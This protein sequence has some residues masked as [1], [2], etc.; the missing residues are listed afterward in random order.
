MQHG[1]AFMQ[2]VKSKHGHYINTTSGCKMVKNIRT[3][4]TQYIHNLDTHETKLKKALLEPW[5]AAH[6]GFDS[7]DDAD[8]FTKFSQTSETVYQGVTGN[9]IDAEDFWTAGLLGVAGRFLT[10]P[11]ID[12]PQEKLLTVPYAKLSQHGALNIEAQARIRTVLGSCVVRKF[13]EWHASSNGDLSR[14]IIVFF[15]ITIVKFC[16]KT[17]TDILFHISLNVSN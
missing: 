9:N 13:E 10:S 15:A 16:C 14:K 4:K 1:Q 5:N 17:V 12:S 7:Q 2:Y 3:A 8:K 11:I 6:G